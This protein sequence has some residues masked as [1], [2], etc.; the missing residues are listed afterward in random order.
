LVIPGRGAL[1]AGVLTL[2]AACAGDIVFDDVPLPDAAVAEPD[3]CHDWLDLH[4]VDYSPGSDTPG[5]DDPITVYPPIAEIHYRVSWLES[6]RQTLFMDCRLAQSLVRMADY[7]RPHDI[8]EVADMGVYNYRCIGGGNPD[9]GCTPSQHAF[10]LAIDIAGFTTDD[11]T[12]LS[13]LDDWVIDPD[14]VPTCEA[15]PSGQANTLLHEVIC[16]LKKD[17]VWN[18]VLTPNYNA[19]H[20]DHFHVDLS[21]GGDFIRARDDG[22]DV[23]G[24]AH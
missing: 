3:N 18:I 21:E 7:L 16:E 10:A 4:G 9:D 17:G 8:V 19:A 22:V 23:G 6:R 12:F 14:D 2:G 13:V 20:R 11:G 15:Q 5:V 24:A 1:V